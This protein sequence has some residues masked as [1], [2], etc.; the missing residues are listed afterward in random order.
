LSLANDGMAF[1]VL[2][3]NE[4]EMIKDNDSSLAVEET[5][6]L[7]RS[8][9]REAFLQ[10]QQPSH[11]DIDFFTFFVPDIVDLCT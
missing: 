2:V 3:L 8:L 5:L 4:R 9:S 1:L 6:M 10:S 7:Q 11:C